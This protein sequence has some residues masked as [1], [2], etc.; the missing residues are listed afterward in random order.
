M[1]YGTRTRVRKMGE[2]TIITDT[3]IVAARDHSETTIYC[4]SVLVEDEREALSAFLK[5]Q[6]DHKIGKI[7]GYGLTAVP[8]QDGIIT[9]IEKTWTV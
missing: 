3:K 9:R 6:D 5:L 4:E 1:N 2:I 8:N 7:K